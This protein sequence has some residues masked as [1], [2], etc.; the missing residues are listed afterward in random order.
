M[1]KI[2]IF[3]KYFISFMIFIGIIFFVMFCYSTYKLVTLE[4]PLICDTT[5]AVIIMNGNITQEAYFVNFSTIFEVDY[6]IGGIR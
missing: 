1:S 4:K 6:S 2:D 5:P 3:L